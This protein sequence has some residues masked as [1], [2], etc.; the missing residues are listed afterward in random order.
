MDQSEPANRRR[1]TA[2]IA[3]AGRACLAIA[4]PVSGSFADGDGY[5]VNTRATAPGQSY[6]S[7]GYG[8][9]PNGQ[10]QRQAPNREG[11]PNGRNCPEDHK[12]N[13]PS[14]GGQQNN[15]GSSGPALPG[16]SVA[17]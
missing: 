15:E 7:P 1:T 17:L 2:I 16:D 10:G 4:I 13:P 9:P 6:G 3:A 11:A 12:G 5:G 14:N 8:Q